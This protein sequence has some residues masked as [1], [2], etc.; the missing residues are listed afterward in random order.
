MKNTYTAL[1]QKPEGKDHLN[2][3]GA[4]GRIILK[5]ILW[6][7]GARVWTG[8]IWLRIRTSGKF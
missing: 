2:D 7:Q 6:K 1:I 5:Y 8:F 3:P 4:D